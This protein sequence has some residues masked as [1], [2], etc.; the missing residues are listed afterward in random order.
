LVLRPGGAF[1][2][3]IAGPDGA[4]FEHF[5]C[6]LDLQPGKRL[7]WTTALAGGW[8]PLPQ[9]DWPPNFTCILTLE[10]V[11]VDGAPGCRYTAEALHASADAARKHAEMGFSDGWGKATDQLVQMLHGRR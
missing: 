8:R 6:F 11:Q 1:N 2:F 10:P 9:A 7:V 5:G 3:T 4:R